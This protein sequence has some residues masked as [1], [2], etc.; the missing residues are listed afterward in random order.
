M[1]MHD[2][3]V[4]NT[5]TAFINCQVQTWPQSLAV[6]VYHAGIFALVFSLSALFY[7]SPSLSTHHSPNFCVSVSHISLPLPLSP[8]PFPLSLSPAV[9]PLNDMFSRSLSLPTSIDYLYVCLLIC[10]ALSLSG[11]VVSI[12]THLSVFFFFL[13]PFNHFL[14]DTP[15]NLSLALSFSPALPLFSFS[16]SV[17]LL[18]S[19]GRVEGGG[20]EV[21][22][23]GCFR[24]MALPLFVM[25]W[26][27]LL[28]YYS[29]SA[30]HSHLPSLVLISLGKVF[31]DR[32]SC[33]PCLYS[34]HSGCV[35]N[36]ILYCIWCTT[37]DKGQGPQCSGQKQCTIYGDG[38]QFRTRVSQEPQLMV[39]S[40][41]GLSLFHQ[42]VA[43]EGTGFQS[44]LSPRPDC[45]LVS[46]SLLGRMHQRL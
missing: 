20:T 18:N 30:R 39:P 3:S 14:S 38:V 22:R 43:Q 21:G 7:L 26:M 44:F 10:A 35:L 17:E 23:D 41:S 37:F 25:R 8:F 9:C 31:F 45:A 32:R 36:G 12:S 24:F 4:K 29:C 5:K 27:P 34:P 6:S 15:V 33:L 1:Q 19:R 46:L 42:K 13:L 28:H 16:L 11:S 40:D 2:V